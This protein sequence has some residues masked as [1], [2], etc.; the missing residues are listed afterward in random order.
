MDTISDLSA[1]SFEPR[2]LLLLLTVAE[3]GSINAAARTLNISQPALSKN[4]SDFEARIGAKV[5]DR[6]LSGTRLTPIGE[7]LCQNARSIR[8]ELARARR[9]FDSMQSAATGTLSIG[10]APIGEPYLL[11][12]SMELFLK[13]WPQ[14]R[15]SVSD[16]SVRDLPASLRRGDI[17]MILGALL[18]VE[19]GSDLVEE[20]LFHDKMVIAVRRDHPLSK[21]PNLTLAETEGMGWIM[22][23]T[24]LRL[25]GLVDNSFRQAG[26]DPPVTIIECTPYPIVRNMVRAG[27]WLATLPLQ[28][29]AND[30]QAGELAVL[31]LELNIPPRPIG[32][33]RRANGHPS[34]DVLSFIGCL[35]E[36]V[37]GLK[38]A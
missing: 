27:D 37:D 23:S 1:A 11:P 2:L 28:S 20:V 29:V 7:A 14:F 22:P 10:S 3:T 21:K 16:E 4:L 6:S 31:N 15:I 32:V 17:D 26:I 18:D 9:Q 24:G 33:I 13:Q 12:R 19:P 25:R 36:A 5:L 34:P 30:L 38:T 8:A 35:K